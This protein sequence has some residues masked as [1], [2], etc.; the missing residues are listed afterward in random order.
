MME[1]LKELESR[2]PLIKD[3]EQ[4]KEVVWMNPE[5]LSME[6]ILK[7]QTLTMADIDDAERRWDRFAPFIRKVF[8]ETEVSEGLIESPLKEIPKM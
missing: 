7:G 8:P 2:F 4:A 1:N 6:E 3:M 5:L